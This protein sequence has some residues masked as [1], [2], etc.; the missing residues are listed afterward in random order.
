MLCRVLT[1]YPVRLEI[2]KLL[3]QLLISCNEYGAHLSARATKA[4]S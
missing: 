2:L 4:A 3:D 1:G